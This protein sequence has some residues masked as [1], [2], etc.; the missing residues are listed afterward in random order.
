[1]FQ[2]ACFFASGILVGD[3]S[4]LNFYFTNMLLSYVLGSLIFMWLAYKNKRPILETLQI[5]GVIL[6]TAILG[7][8]IAHALFEARGHWLS[9]GLIAQN[10][11]ELFQDDPWHGLRFSDPGYVFYGGLAAC[12]FLSFFWPKMRSYADYAVPGL[13]LGIFLGRLGCFYTGCCYGVA[14]LPVQLLDAGFGL[15]MLCSIRKFRSFLIIYSLWRFG[16]EFLRA[17][18]N[19]GIWAL[20]LSTSQW[21]ALTILTISLKSSQMRQ[22]RI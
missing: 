6:L 3:E 9:N 17:D 10:F 5:L 13:C 15:I 19:R 22:T 2:S 4:A 8:K 16:L 7:S 12:F 14:G 11:W 18:E 21:I 1:M 20:W